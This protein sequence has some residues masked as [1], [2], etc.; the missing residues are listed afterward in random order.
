MEQWNDGNASL[1]RRILMMFSACYRSGDFRPVYPLLADTCE[2]AAPKGTGDIRGRSE[3]QTYFSEK[4]AFMRR[5]DSCPRCSLVRLNH[6]LTA[7][8]ADSPENCPFALLVEQGR[9]TRQND[10]LL[11]LTLDAFGMI[12]RIDF[13]IPGLQSYTFFREDMP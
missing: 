6:P 3:V 8:E 2:I 1:L 7:Q 4:G 12:C 10:V 5:Y 11:L 13:R 9:W